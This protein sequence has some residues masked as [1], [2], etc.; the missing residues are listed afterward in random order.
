LRLVSHSQTQTGDFTVPQADELRAALVALNDK[1]NPDAKDRIVH[2]ERDL[3]M[4]PGAVQVC[5]TDCTTWALPAHPAQQPALRD[6]Q[7]LAGHASLATTQ[8]YIQ[9]NSDAKQN[10]V[11]LRPRSGEAPSGAF[12]LKASLN[13]LGNF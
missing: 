7:E 5:S 9:G 6:V 8:R 1:R 11:N 13:S 4:S 12:P 10:V 3:G 2:S